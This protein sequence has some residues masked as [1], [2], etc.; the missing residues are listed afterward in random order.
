MS[1]SNQNNNMASILH[2]F[3]LGR[4]KTTQELADIMGVRPSYI[5]D[6]ERNRRN[7]SRDTLLKYAAALDVPY[8]VLEF[9]NEEATTYGYTFR[10]ILISVLLLIEKMENEAEE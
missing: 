4:E 6:V 7:P 2:A 5:S 9:F 1:A 8:S 10:K 3:R